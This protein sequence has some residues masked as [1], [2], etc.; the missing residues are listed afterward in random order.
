MKYVKHVLYN[1][2]T[3]VV[4]PPTHYHAARAFK[5]MIETL[6]HERSMNRKRSQDKRNVRLI[7]A[8]SFGVPTCCLMLD[9]SCLTVAEAATLPT[10]IRQS[11]CADSCGGDHTEACGSADG[12]YVSLFENVDASIIG[13]TDIPPTATSPGTHLGC[14]NVNHMEPVFTNDLMDTE[15]CRVHST[16]V[17][18]RF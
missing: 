17:E 16:E 13:V 4:H 2:V 1:V 5:S 11:G 15:V 7:A 9:C 3:A 10:Y 12:N 14:F 6:V 8:L 18:S